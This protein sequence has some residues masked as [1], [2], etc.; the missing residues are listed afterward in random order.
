MALDALKALKGDLRI[1]GSKN[2]L[3]EVE[4]DGCSI[5]FYANH[6]SFSKRGSKME[7]WFGFEVE[8][9]V[10]LTS[11]HRSKISF[12]ADGEHV[13]QRQQDL[14]AFISKL[15]ADVKPEPRFNLAE[16]ARTA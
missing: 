2:R 9:K 15:M 3:K 16:H 4:T 13:K 1:A 11:N 7:E 8:N 12:W 10:Y 6:L 5:R 14:E